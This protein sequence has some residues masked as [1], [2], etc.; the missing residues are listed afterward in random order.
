MDLKSDCCCPV[1]DFNIILSDPMFCTANSPNYPHGICNLCPA[2][3]RHI[4]SSDRLF[5]RVCFNTYYITEQYGESAIRNEQNCVQFYCENIKLE[6]RSINISAS[7]NLIR[8]CLSATNHIK[9]NLK[10]YS[11][12]RKEEFYAKLYQI[13]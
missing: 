9:L 10:S 12:N 13:T 4:V 5:C 2:I 1:Q 7:L 6:T 3:Y 11:S 8:D